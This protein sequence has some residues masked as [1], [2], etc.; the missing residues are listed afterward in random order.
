MTIEEI[1]QQQ[2]K[3]IE[4]LIKG[5]QMQQQAYEPASSRRAQRPGLTPIQQ[6]H[7][8]VDEPPWTPSQFARPLYDGGT[9]SGGFFQDCALDNALMNLLIHPV[10]G[11]A[12]AIPIRPNNNE[13]TKH[14]FLTRYNIDEDSAFVD[15]GGPCDPCIPIISD[16]DFVKISFPYAGLCRSIHTIDIT[17]LILRACN[18]QFDDFYIIGNYRGVSASIPNNTFQDSELI[19]VG[20]V[21]R[22]MAELGTVFQR[23]V[24]RYVWTGDPANGDTGGANTRNSQFYG[25]LRLITGNYPASGLP[26]TGAQASIANSSALNSVVINAAGNC[27]GNGTFSTY[28]ALKEVERT[29][30]QR[31]SGTGVL[32]VDWRIYMISPL[33]DELARN[34]ACEM[35]AD[36]C[37]V[38]GGD[39]SKVLNMNDG[40]MALYNISSYNEMIRTQSIVLN[41]RVY[42][43]YLDDT[44]PYTKAAAVSPATGFTYTSSIFFIPFTAAGGEQ[45]L[46][47]EYIDYSQIYGELGSLAAD[48]SG[49]TDNG[50]YWH[51]ITQVR[52][53]IELQTQMSL[54][55]IFKAP[56]LAGRIDN[57]CANTESAQILFFDGAGA[58]VNGLATSSVRT[59]PADPV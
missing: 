20:A 13:T 43:V 8:L 12:N 24:L 2:N 10:D 26:I 52:N 46:F 48:T 38:P 42:P 58:P 7:T 19:K 36:G 37:T 33:W 23:W 17:S 21:Q 49:W 39:P 6:K 53:C 9:Y 16:M 59:Q 35:A 3:L 25:L 32:P 34:I 15:A 31:A 11:I 57:L 56:H 51:Q 5:Q 30:Y 45:V 29:L 28:A 41:G 27:V 50:Q 54:R 14:G 1:L 47:W 22:K 44:M 4:T 18:N 55:L 40:G